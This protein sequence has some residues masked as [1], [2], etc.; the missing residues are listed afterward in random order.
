MGQL[1]NFSKNVAIWGGLLFIA[2]TS[3]QTALL[4]ARANG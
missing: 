4:H 1:I 2:G 3:K